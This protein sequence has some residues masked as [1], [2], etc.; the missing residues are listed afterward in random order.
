MIWASL[1]VSSLWIKASGS[2]WTSAVSGMHH[3][4]PQQKHP[5]LISSCLSVWV[6]CWL[7]AHTWAVSSVEQSGFVFAQQLSTEYNPG[8]ILQHQELLPLETRLKCIMTFNNFTPSFPS[9]HSSA[10]WW[11]AQV[12]HAPS[13]TSLLLPPMSSHGTA[14]PQS[15]S[16]LQRSQNE[17]LQAS[18]G[19]DFHEGRVVMQVKKDPHCWGKFMWELWCMSWLIPETQEVGISPFPWLL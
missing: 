19:W 18:V 17:S 4:F 2:V 12:L 5:P 16:R 3:S 14:A 15:P 11:G 6:L 13:G 1:L 7:S 10:W 8:H 9:L